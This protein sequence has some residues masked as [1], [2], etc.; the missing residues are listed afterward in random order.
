VARFEKLGS[1]NGWSAMLGK[2]VSQLLMLGDW[3]SRCWR[4][5]DLEAC[6]E[7]SVVCIC[8]IKPVV[9]ILFV[10]H[11]VRMIELLL[12]CLMTGGT[13]V[14]IFWNYES[15]VVVFEGRSGTTEQEIRCT[16]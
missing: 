1:E 2:V 7:R 3:G 10:E 4:C 8:F 16:C 11:V 12:A 15:G 6:E 14:L 9:K 13:Q 5:G